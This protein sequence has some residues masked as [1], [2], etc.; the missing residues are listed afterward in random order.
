MRVWSRVLGALIG[1]VSTV[2][3]AQSATALPIAPPTPEP[4]AGIPSPCVSKTPWPAEAG[5][6]RTRQ[7][8]QQRFDLTLTGEGWNRAEY[9]PIV[10]I[11]WETLDGISCTP[12]LSQVLAQLDGKP[13]RIHAGSTR[14]WAWGDWSLTNPGALTFDFSKFVQA[15]DDKDPGRLVRLVVHELGHVRNMDRY[16]NPAYWNAFLNVQRNAGRFS[17]YGG[18]D[19]TEV[20]QEVIGYY[21]ARCAKNNPYDKGHADY[22]DFAKTFIFNGVE[23][24]PKPGQ[25][26][27]CTMSS[28]EMKPP[29]GGS[30]LPNWLAP[31]STHS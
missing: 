9:R 16:S 4:V 15:L 20:L 25:A 14:S 29:P 12:Y 30:K 2:L 13:L 11:I 31:R 23:F 1:A 6:E 26:V 27:D 19:P 5:R 24:G 3:V 7:L 8:M 21:V 18:S 17:D 10:K 22:Y 28:G